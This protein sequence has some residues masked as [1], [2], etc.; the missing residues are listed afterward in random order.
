MDTTNRLSKLALS[1]IAIALTAIL[2]AIFAGFGTRLKVW[3]FG[4]GFM[5]LKWGTILAI[6]ALVLSLAALYYT[7]IRKR[8]HGT[9]LALIGVIL[10]VITVMPPLFWLQRAKSLPMIH[11]ISTDTNNPPR[12][13]SVLPLRR[14]AVNT[15]EYG[16]T[17]IAALQHQAYPDIEPVIIQQKLQDVFNAAL[18]VARNMGWHIISSDS[19]SG[20][21]EATDTTFW[22]GFTDDVVIRITAQ[23][24]A[25]RVDVRSLSRVGRSDVG[26]NARRISTFLKALRSYLR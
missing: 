7:F 5:L 14:N 1:G 25:T 8:S 15:T 26:T 10:A 12:F 17:E 11:D 20:R 23:D 4:T 9:P 19:T 21:I 2:L 16:G 22:F 6:V 3:P 18:I 24:R 13:E